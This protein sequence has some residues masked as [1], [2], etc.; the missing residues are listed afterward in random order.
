MLTSVM[1]TA[2]LTP[3]KPRHIN[4]YSRTSGLNSELTPLFDRVYGIVRLL[5]PTVGF[6]RQARADPSRLMKSGIYRN[7]SLSLEGHAAYKTPI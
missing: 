2:C 1:F 6:S 4:V 5:R 3:I 7:Q